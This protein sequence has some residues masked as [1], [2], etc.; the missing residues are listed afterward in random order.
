MIIIIRNILNQFRSY[1]LV[2]PLK[3]LHISHF[4]FQIL[5]FQISNFKFQHSILI[6]SF[7]GLGVRDITNKRPLDSVRKLNISVEY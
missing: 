4:N 2:Y 6:C 1:R 3:F 7:I 5:K